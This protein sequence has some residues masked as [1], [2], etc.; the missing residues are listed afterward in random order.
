[1]LGCNLRETFNDASNASENSIKG[2]QARQNLMNGV[3]V[4]VVY[5]VLMVLVGPWLWNNVLRRLVPACGKARWYD[6][7]LLGVLIGLLK[8]N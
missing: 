3:A 6:I 8:G 1:M 7:I 4:V 5:L 2:E